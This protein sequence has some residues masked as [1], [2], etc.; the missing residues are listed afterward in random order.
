MSIACLVSIRSPDPSTKH[1][2]VIV[3]SNNRILGVGYNGWP[4]G[5][6][7]SIYPTTRPDKYKYMIHSEKNAI[8]NCTGTIVDATLYVTGVP[9]NLCMQDIIQAGIKRVC[10]GN[11]QSAC[12]E[13]SESYEATMLMAN[14]HGIEMKPYNGDV[15]SVFR[16][17]IVYLDR[18]WGT[19]NIT[20]YSD[21][22]LGLRPD[23]YA[24]LKRSF[25]IR[26]CIDESKEKDQ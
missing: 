14:N 26:E 18:K 9:C 10:F 6:D 25:E 4:R 1:G 21:D 8:N 16:K 19:N 13:G 11:I 17:L 2:S 24:D 12:V 5:G 23:L 7:E 20:E 22:D 15:Y 3:D